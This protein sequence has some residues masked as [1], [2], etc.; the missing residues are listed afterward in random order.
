MIKEIRVRVIFIYAILLL[1][2]F[3]ASAAV[4][5]S[6]CQ[7]YMQPTMVPGIGIGYQPI[8]PISFKDDGSIEKED[9]VDLKTEDGGKTQIF[10]YKVPGGFPTQEGAEIKTN[11]IYMQVTVKSDDKG[12][13]T[14]VIQGDNQTTEMLRNFDSWTRRSYENSVPESIRKQNDET[15]GGSDK[16]Y[17]P[18]F[19][20]YKGRTIQFDVKNGKCVPLKVSLSYYTEPKKDGES[21]EITQLD[22]QLCRDVN[23]FIKANPEASA[24]FRKDINDRMGM[25]FKKHIPNYQEEAS[26]IMNS[27]TPFGGFGS[28][29]GYGSMGGGGF[30]GMGG[31]AM[32][33]LA[34][35][36]LANDETFLKNV[37]DADYLAIKRRFGNSPVMN[38]QRILQSCF[39][40]GVRDIIEDESIWSQRSRESSRD[41]PASAEEK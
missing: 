11:T 36:I 8:V 9:F 4:D 1:F 5:Y 3:A 21:I 7:A 16:K 27:G 18:P 12:N 6:A 31:F 30:G 24:C 25:I 22:T 34:N 32:N 20:A 14:E 15:L 28:Y 19:F 35:N 39:D 13:I 37:N 38:G 29:G 10:T 26:N 17:S 33:S 23:E 40:G 2:S 41:T